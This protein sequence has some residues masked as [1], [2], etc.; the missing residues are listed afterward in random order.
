MQ[1]VKGFVSR[2]DFISNADGVVSPIFEISPNSL[3]YNRE[4]GEYQDNN[5]PESILHTFQSVDADG[6]TYELPTTQVSEVFQIVNAVL[7]YVSSHSA[8]YDKADFLATINVGFSGKVTDFDYGDLVNTAVQIVP[9]WLTWKSVTHPDTEVKIWLADLAFQEQFDGYKIITVPPIDL[10]DSFFGNY[11]QMV[12]ALKAITFSIMQ[13]RCQTARADR[14]ST[15]IRAYDFDYVNPNNTAQKTTVPWAVLVYGKNGDNIDTIKDE[16][17][18]YILDHSTHTREEWEVIFPDLFK[19]TEFIFLPRWDL[20]A[21]PNLT[22]YSSIYSSMIDPYESISFAKGVL[23]TMPAAFIDNN[24]TVIPFDF[25]C[26]STLCVNGQ[27][28]VEGKKAIEDIFPDYIPVPTTSVDFDRMSE[29]TRNWVLNMQKLLKAA[30]TAT[31]YSTVVN[32][33]RR[34]KRNGMIYLSL[35]YNNINFLVAAASNEVFDA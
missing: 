15:Y 35:Y 30:E 1:I 6:N 19:R 25:K 10:L 2:S 5:Y 18:E 16:I 31:Q 7:S 12:T 4:R 17:V 11:G 14:P 13:E 24:L 34:V 26:I 32:P 9:E 33:M 20:V 27:N 29:N 8:P 23:S 21:I 28:N 3:T 22:V